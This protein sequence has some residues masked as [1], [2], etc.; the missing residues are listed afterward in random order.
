VG[1]DGKEI[2]DQLAREGF[3]HP[4]TGPQPALGTYVKVARGVIMDWTHSKHEEH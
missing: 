3:S 1:T 2:A 4:I